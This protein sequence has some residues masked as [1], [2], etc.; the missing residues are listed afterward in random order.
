MTVTRVV[1]LGVAALVVALAVTLAGSA[2]RQAGTNSVLETGQAAELTDGG[3]NCQPGETIPADAG[4][5]RL[6]V[7]TYGLPLPELTVTARLP[8]GT[9]V[10]SGRRPPGGREGY[11]DIPLRRVER[12]TAGAEVCI[13][14]EGNPRTVLYG[15]GTAVNL[16]WLRP[17]R[18]SWFAL[19]PTVAH[20][21]ALGKA[22]L[23]GSLWL[24]VVALVMVVACALAL[25]LVLREP[26]PRA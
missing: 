23:F 26:G 24:L 1:A 25:R 21:F 6:L 20:R 18:E 16:N 9:P 22:S 4:E 17:G 12:T 2:E 8:D 19:I 5:V 15:E 3:E 11:V 10:T 13:R 7:G 14:A